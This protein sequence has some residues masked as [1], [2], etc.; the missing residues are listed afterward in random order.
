MSGR[1]A[2]KVRQHRLPVSKLRRS[3]I[4]VLSPETICSIL[5]SVIYQVMTNSAKVCLTPG[6]RFAG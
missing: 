4:Q 6:S 5:G 1:S 3:E 2:L